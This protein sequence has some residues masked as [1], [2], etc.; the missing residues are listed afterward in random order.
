MSMQTGPKIITDGL[1]LALDAAD[2]GSYPGA[3]TAWYDLT[4]NGNN[5]TINLGEYVSSPEGGYLRNVNNTSSLFYVGIS[6]ST[7]ISNTFSVTTGGWTIE[8]IIWTNSV[9]YPE[10]DAGGVGSINAGF[11]GFDWNHGI[12]N[13]SF[14]FGQ[15]SNSS[16]TYQDDGTFVVGS[17]YNSLNAW[18]IRTIIWNRGS[19]LNSLYINGTFINSLSTT[20]TS[21]M[22]I[23]DGGGIVFGALYGWNHYGRRAAIKI[24][25]RVLS[26][27]EVLQN[28]KALKPRFK[29][30]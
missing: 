19:N 7:S 18:R 13:T 24:Y 26:A 3:G 21:G 12:T 4:G 8:E 20:N 27:T 6:N 11:T 22:A 5:G 14:R 1:V 9:V 10:A 2:L 28:Y 30:N 16:G 23:Y 25:N 17:P 15:S 29:L